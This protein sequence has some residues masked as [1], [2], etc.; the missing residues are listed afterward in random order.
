MTFKLPNSLR[1]AGAGQE[2]MFGLLCAIQGLGFE[3][4]HT[5]AYLLHAPAV[6][7]V[8]SPLSPAPS[9]VAPFV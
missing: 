1:T 9:D 5:P 6:A 3:A 4:F 2:F 8:F 7:L